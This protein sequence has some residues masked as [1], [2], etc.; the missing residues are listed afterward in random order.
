MGKTIIPTPDGAL[1]LLTWLPRHAGRETAAHARAGPLPS[2]MP[3]HG[4]THCPRAAFQHP[5][6]DH[7]LLVGHPPVRRA[8]SLLLSPALT[9]DLQSP[10][11]VA[12]SAHF[13]VQH[14]PGPCPPAAPGDPRRFQPA[15]PSCRSR[16]RLMLTGILDFGDMTLSPRICDLA[17]AASYL[18]DPEAP[19]SLL[20]PLVT[21]YHARLPLLPQELRLL[22]DLITARMLTTLTIAGWRAARYPENAAYIL[23]NAP[24]AETGLLVLRKA[25]PARLADALLTA[26]ERPSP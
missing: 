3:W 5:A 19:L 2:A 22:P 25:D 21:A 10:T 23:R 8:A 18:I 24:S 1:R 13:T 14:R 20:L 11:S 7:V 26:C 4:S 9:E 17:V 16:T 6:D 15:Q 12:L